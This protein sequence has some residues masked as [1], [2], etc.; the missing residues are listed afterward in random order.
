LFF[1]S[2][3]ATTSDN[4]GFP[5]IPLLPVSRDTRFQPRLLHRLLPDLPGPQSCDLP[6]RDRIPSEGPGEMYGLPGKYR[7]SRTEEYIPGYLQQSPLGRTRC[8]S[9]EQ[10]S[11]AFPVYIRRVRRGFRPGLCQLPAARRGPL[12]KYAPWFEML[13]RR[14]P[15][16]ARHML[17]SPWTSRHLIDLSDGR[18]PGRGSCCNDTSLVN[19]NEVVCSRI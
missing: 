3:N 16:P 18:S 6:T 9:H 14:P 8:F 7:P 15:L 1:L 17:P 11:G 12:P 5:W 13:A 19:L 4:S 2:P 10:L